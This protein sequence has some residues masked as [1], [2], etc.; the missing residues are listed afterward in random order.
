MIYIID[1]N[2]SILESYHLER[3]LHRN[4]AY[5][6]ISYYKSFRFSTIE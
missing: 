3:L 4:I 2:I 1:M 5:K 6:L